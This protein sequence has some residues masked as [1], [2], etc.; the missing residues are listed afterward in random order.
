MLALYCIYLFGM[1][2][3]GRLYQSHFSGDVE[4]YLAN[5]WESGNPAQIYMD[6]KSM[7]FLWM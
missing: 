5:G 3:Q 7:F 1:S 6:P 4:D 2:L